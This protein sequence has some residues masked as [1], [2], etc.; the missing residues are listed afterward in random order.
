MPEVR[1]FE[2][3]GALDGGKTGLDYYRKLFEQ[4][5]ATRYTLHATLFFEICPHQF[6]DIKILA[7][8]F[9]SRAQV[10]IVKDL[11]GINRVAIIKI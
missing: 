11:A 9:F 1:N 6:D 5:N 10:K 2:P 7:R 4:L 8:T 3:R